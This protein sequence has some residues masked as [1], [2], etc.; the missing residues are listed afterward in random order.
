MFVF[1]TLYFKIICIL[2]QASIY[3]C[4]RG[5]LGIRIYIF[6]CLFSITRKDLFKK[7]KVLQ[8]SVCRH[9]KAYPLS[10]SEFNM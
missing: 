1:I 3:P 9:S 4:Q 5:K 8:P 10:E 6:V 7:K 2:Q